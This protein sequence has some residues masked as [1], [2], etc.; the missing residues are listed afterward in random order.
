MTGREPAAGTGPYLVQLL[1]LAGV[2]LAA[3]KLSLLLA[4]PP[5]Y[6]TPVWPP[7]GIA[8]AATLL[9]GNRI[10]PGIWL[11]AAAANLT[12]ESSVVT[13]VLIAS[14]N[15][16]EALAGAILIRRFIG[17]PCRFQRGEDVVTFVAAAV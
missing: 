10:W 11:G 2:Y 15:T 6:A 8:M 12:I 7:S 9:L 17:V 14:G 1:V 4:I 13:A 5:G 3:A 16:L